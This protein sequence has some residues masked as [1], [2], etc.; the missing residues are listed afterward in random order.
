MA[1]SWSLFGLLAAVCGGL[2]ASLHALVGRMDSLSSELRGEMQ[3]LAADLRGE[4]RQLRTDISGRMDR[5]DGRMDALTAEVHLY[6]A[7]VDRRLRDGDL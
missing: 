7:D 6:H 5:A 1:L 2:L 3:S 4:M